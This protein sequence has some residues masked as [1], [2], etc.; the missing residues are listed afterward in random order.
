MF[1]FAKKKVKTQ[2]IKKVC[3][4]NNCF[5]AAVRCKVINIKQG[6]LYKQ[7]FSCQKIDLANKIEGMKN[8]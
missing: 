8:L 7:M 1:N 3:V 6:Q 2:S 5:F 4:C